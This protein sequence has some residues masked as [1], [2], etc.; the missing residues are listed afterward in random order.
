MFNAGH[1]ILMWVSKCKAEKKWL[2]D[3]ERHY[4]LIGSSYTSHL[5]P[6][7][8]KQYSLRWVTSKW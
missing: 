4:N 5:Y 2:H 8:K 7:S 3:I 6:L 1:D